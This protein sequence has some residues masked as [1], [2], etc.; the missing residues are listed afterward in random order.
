MMAVDR[1]PPPPPLPQPRQQQ[2]PAQ[3]GGQQQYQRPSADVACYDCGKPGHRAAVCPDAIGPPSRATTTTA[4][5]VAALGPQQ[6]GQGGGPRGGYGD[7]HSGGR[8]GG[9]GSGAG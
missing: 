7:G 1:A 3:Q 4:G 2:Q 8:G 5:A 6:G 9:C